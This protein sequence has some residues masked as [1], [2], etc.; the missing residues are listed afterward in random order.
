MY[1]FQENILRSPRNVSETPGSRILTDE[2][3][4]RDGGRQTSKVD[5]EN[6]GQT[7]R[8]QSILDVAQIERVSEF[9]IVDDPTKYFFC[10]T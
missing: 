8:I 7:Q 4:K 10:S 1:K 2:T 5:E 9:D 6:C 3:P